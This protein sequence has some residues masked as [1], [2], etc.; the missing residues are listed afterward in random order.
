MAGT[1]GSG[2]AGMAGRDGG[3][4]G[5]AGATDAG[6]ITDAARDTARD[7]AADTSRPND[8]GDG[9]GCSCRV[10]R[11]ES[12]GSIAWL[13]LL[14]AAVLRPRLRRRRSDHSATDLR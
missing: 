9:D 14:A 11:T 12:R 2:A 3:S 7:V 1:A 5:S 8:D 13:M 6:G 10:G 4:A